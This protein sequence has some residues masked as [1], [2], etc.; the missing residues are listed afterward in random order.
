MTDVRCCRGCDTQLTPMKHPG[1]PKVWCSEA[2]RVRTHRGGGPRRPAREPFT[3]ADCGHPMHR[4]SNSLPQGQARCQPCRSADVAQGSRK[5]PCIDCG[6]PS[7]GSRCRPCSDKVPRLP[8]IRHDDDVRVMRRA[9]EDAAPGLTRGSRDRLLAKWRRQ[10][11]VC[12]YCPAL[13]DTVD[14]VVPLVRGGTNF[15]GNL[16]PCCRQCNGTK[17]ARTVAEWRHGKRA[18]RCLVLMPWMSTPP[19]DRRRRLRWADPD[20]LFVGCE[21]CGDLYVSA[22]SR[23]YCTPRCCDRASLARRGLLPSP[24]AC[25][26]CAD[27]GVPLDNVKRMKCDDCVLATNRAGRKRR[28]KAARLRGAKWAR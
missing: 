15:E 18:G 8:R 25:A 20:P 1:R 7:Y 13:A 2:C 21:F 3:C 24:R 5:S 26:D 14:H 22:R 4:G 23:R 16:V 11:R 9:R 28:R 12:A 10:G 19:R 27:C 17:H 6:R